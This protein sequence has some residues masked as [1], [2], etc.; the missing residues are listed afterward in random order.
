MRDHFDENTPPHKLVELMLFYSVPRK[1]TNDLAH[2]LLNH[3]GSLSAILSATPEQLKEVPGIGDNTVCLIKLITTVN[4]IA[5][6]QAEKKTVN[7]T[8]SFEKAYELLSKQYFAV[9]YEMFSVACFKSNG[10]MISWEILGKGDVTQVNISLRKL[11]EIVIKTNAAAVI[12]AHNHPNG[13]AL[14]SEDDVHMTQTIR[15]ALTNIGVGLLDHVVF[16]N[17]DYVSMRQTKKYEYLFL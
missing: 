13:T 4:K 2:E 14:P 1:D 8:Q 12:I 7:V 17:D 5:S 16:A 15:D 9:E 6:L 3:F 10:E 11:M